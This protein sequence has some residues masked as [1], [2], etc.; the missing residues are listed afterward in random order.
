M[1]AAEENE[2]GQAYL[3]NVSVTEAKI[4][5][6]EKDDTSHPETWATLAAGD[7]NEETHGKCEFYCPC[8]LEKGDKVRLRR[9]SGEYYQNIMFDVI[10]PET[11]D[12]MIDEATQQPVT[13]NR[14]YFIPPRYSLYPMQRH[15]CDL[16]SRLN[17]LSQVIKEQGGVVLNSSAGSYIVNLNIPAGQSHISNRPRIRLSDTDDFGAAMEGR[18]RRIHRPSGQSGS[19][20]QGI[21]EIKALAQML[22]D[23]EFDK[24]Q[25]QHVILRIGQQG[26][27]L[28]E[29]YQSDPLTMYRNLYG[30][31]H[32]QANMPHANHNHVA[33]FRFRPIGDRKFWKRQ[34][35]GSMTVQGQAEQIHDRDGKL[36]YVS[37]RINFQ[38]ESAFRTFEEEYRKNKERSFLVYTEHAT[39]NTADYAAKKHRLDQDL[40][41]HTTV[42]ADTV[43][44]SSA[45]MMPW[46]PRS[47]QLTLFDGFK[48]PG[49]NDDTSHLD[50]EAYEM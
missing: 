47:P 46:A 49:A 28:A 48:S 8:C 44:Y 5:D 43:V 35:D 10:D 4:F 37:A 25:R 33:L 11:G 16:A 36:F 27:T 14:R 45:Q 42:F 6:P 38:T 9:P 21:R 17:N 22:D 7:Y 31:E 15:T 19:Q 20:S 26:M 29:A 1:A 39:V 2:S 24:G 23:T 30:Q 13:E 40:D 12:V 32:P 18:T 41:P 50:T 34:E 3:A